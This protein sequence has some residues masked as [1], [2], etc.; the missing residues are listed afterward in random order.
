MT[1]KILSNSVSNVEGTST[2]DPTCYLVDYKLLVALVL[3]LVLFTACEIIA[4]IEKTDVI[5]F[6][7]SS[8]FLY[9]FADIT[10]DV[11]YCCPLQCVLWYNTS[12]FNSLCTQSGQVRSGQSV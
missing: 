2:F 10:A 7:F 4:N 5:G 6:R 1:F 11:R 9:F 12:D 3:H 8:F